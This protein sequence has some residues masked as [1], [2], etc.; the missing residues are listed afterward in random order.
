MDLSKHHYSHNSLE[1]PPAHPIKL[2]PNKFIQNI[3]VLSLFLLCLIG[4]TACDLSYQGDYQAK[5]KI[6]QSFVKKNHLNKATPTSLDSI[7]NLSFAAF[8]PDKKVKFKQ[9]GKDI[10]LKVTVLDAPQKITEFTLSVYPKYFAEIS[11][12]NFANQTSY[13]EPVS[14]YRGHSNKNQHF[15]SQR[16]AF[17]I[18]RENINNSHFLLISSE[19]NRFVKVD[20]VDTNSYIRSDSNFSQFFTVVYSIILAMILFNAVFYFTTR[21]ASYLLYTLYM[22]TTL[23][24]LLWQEGKINDLPWLAWHVIGNQ[25]QFVFFIISDAVAIWF[26]YQFMRLDFRRS[27]GVKIVVLCVLFR[28]G[29]MFTA[30]F[31]FHFMDAIQYDLLSTLFN[32]S[33]I[34]S[35]LIVWVI[36][37]TKT[38]SGYPQA[39]YL[40][41][42]WSIMIFTIALR[43]AFAFNPHPDLIWM[44]HSYELGVMLEG[45]ILAF[46]MANRTLEFRTQRDQ[47]VIK[48][49]AAERSIQ[50]QQLITQ[51]QNEMQELVKD[52]TLS[53]DEV[54]EKL[55]IKFHLTINKAFPIKHSMI[56]M[57]DQLI[58]ICTTGLKP[59]DIDLINFKLNKLINSDV[60]EQTCQFEISTTNNTNRN[61]LY[62]PLKG[63]DIKQTRLI[64][65][66]KKNLPNNSNL[67]KEFKSFCE[68]AYESLNHAREI[69]QVAMAANLDG[70][71][72]CHNR[73]SINAVIK[74]SL[75]TASRTTVGYIDIDDLKH[76]NDQNGHASGDESI[77]EFVDLLN[78]TLKGQAKIGRLGGDEFIAVFTDVSFELCED[79]ME[80]FMASL[81][82]SQFT[83]NHLNITTSIGLA[84]SRIDETTQSL[85][86]KAD[87]AL[88]HAKSQGKNQ[89]SVYH[90]DMLNKHSSQP[91]N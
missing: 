24:S 63:K 4:L 50:K 17:N 27:W 82:N 2:S 81:A 72:G 49:T 16:F 71:T 62:L 35:S 42:A 70:M 56:H 58:G 11:Y 12:F 40:F 45:L 30:V 65:S 57:E 48:F 85:I 38:L 68:A 32:Y 33:I 13:S 59:L 23:Y 6:E 22:I 1:H 79:L 89:I 61:F 34:I 83:S 43:I 25:S 75:K 14:L 31:Q 55:N 84:E 28:L 64:L 91:S 47:A 73:N 41:I 78:Q 26:F 87:A 90:L 52:P 76:I 10:L 7:S 20:V 21:D 46:A 37:L 67:I 86:N 9:Q 19:R 60:A 80:A 74:E 88:Y 18:D 53:A 29:I 51:F 39:K 5:L 69:H 15:S 3:T 36:M 8:N 44:A 54:I 66:L 77:I